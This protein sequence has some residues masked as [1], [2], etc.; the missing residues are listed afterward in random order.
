MITLR[1]PGSNQLLARADKLCCQL[2]TDLKLNYCYQE[3]TQNLGPPALA[4]SLLLTNFRCHFLRWCRSFVPNSLTGVCS[5]FNQF[6]LKWKSN[7]QFEPYLYKQLWEDFIL[8]IA[9]FRHSLRYWIFL[10]YHLFSLQPV[11]NAFNLLP[12]KAGPVFS[13]LS[14]F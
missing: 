9:S 8:K 13:L 7:N 3:S 11:I 1:L 6:V 10:E 2:L 12:S 5:L 14:M 4:L